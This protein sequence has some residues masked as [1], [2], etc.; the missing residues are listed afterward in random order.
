[1]SEK[2][3]WHLF[4]AIGVELE[5]M[6]VDRD[7]LDIRPIADELIKE[8]AGEYRN[9]V[10]RGAISWSN[11]LALHVI[12]L[13]TNG[14]ADSLDGLDMKFQEQ[15]NEINRRL[16]PRNAMLLPTAMHPWMDPD[17]EMK[18]WPHE[19]NPIYEAYNRIFDCRGHGWANLQS[20]HINLPFVG[21]EEFEKLHAAIRVLLPILP[22]IAASSPISD[23]QITGFTDFRMEVYRSNSK[24]IPSVTG[25]IVPE[26]VFTEE[27]YNRE[28][29]QRMYRDIAPY[30]PDG[31]LQDEWLN[32]RGAIARFDRGSI[33]IR[34]LDIQESPLADLALVRLVVDTLNALVEERLG[35]LEAQKSWNEKKLYEILLNVIEE[36][37]KA[38]IPID[39]LQLFGISADTEMTVNRLWN[40]IFNEIYTTDYETPD[41][42]VR[43]AERILK[44][45][46]LSSRIVKS[47]N[48]RTP[49]KGEL[50]EVYRSLS[51]VLSEGKLFKDNE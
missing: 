44:T 43:T 49:G 24:R 47:F 11:E 5:Y 20:T 34:V 6:I 50:M 41:P 2:K 31:I 4:E 35:S 42:M 25:L 51:G 13:K 23:A 46:T 37:E 14:P 45:G 30:D 32:S 12:E 29:F 22:G 15:V 9:E 26:A 33:E 39:F 10:E 16:K 40:Y 38:E 3:Q 19:Y 27:D 18:L 1:M 28:I 7:S 17:K 36:G 48:G 21:D 8:V